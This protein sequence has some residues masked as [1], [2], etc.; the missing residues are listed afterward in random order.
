MQHVDVIE[1]TPFL[2]EEI[3][4]YQKAF[5]DWFYEEEPSEFGGTVRK[6]RGDL[7]CEYFDVNIIVR[8]INEVSKNSDAKIIA[9]GLT[10][11]TEDTNLPSMYF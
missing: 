4:E 1:F 9:Q 8:W 10:P 6:P 5:E 2:G 11:G 3:E 7:N